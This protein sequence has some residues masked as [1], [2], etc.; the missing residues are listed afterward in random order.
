MAVIKAIFLASPPT[1]CSQSDASGI[2]GLAAHLLTDG[3]PAQVPSFLGFIKDQLEHVLF[4]LWFNSTVPSGPDGSIDFGFIDE[5]KYTGDIAYTPL[6]N[7]NG[8]CC[9]MY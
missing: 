6:Y 4:T 2:L 8:I 1:F 9:P 5:T 7:V 3:S